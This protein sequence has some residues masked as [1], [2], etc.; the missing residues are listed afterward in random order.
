MGKKKSSIKKLTRLKNEVPVTG[1]KSK[2]VDTRTG[3]V[4]S[5]IGRKLTKHPPKGGRVNKGRTR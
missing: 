3:K 1:R 5:G 4:G 2:T